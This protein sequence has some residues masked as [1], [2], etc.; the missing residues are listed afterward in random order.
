MRIHMVVLD[1]DMEC[2]EF[3]LAGED[4]Y[5][6][7]VGQHC[8]YG[9]NAYLVAR[10]KNREVAVVGRCPGYWVGARPDVDEELSVE[11]AHW[12]A[13]SE[14]LKAAGLPVVPEAEEE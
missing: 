1:Q 14:D 9:K 13:T 2:E 8:W 10:S 11:L 6:T 12:G 3:A 7:G 4:A 5:Y